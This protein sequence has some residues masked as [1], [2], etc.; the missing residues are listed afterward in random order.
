LHAVVQKNG[1]YTSFVAVEAETVHCICITAILSAI[2]FRR[3]V[4]IV[5]P[6]TPEIAIQEHRYAG[7]TPDIRSSP[8]PF[9]RFSIKRAVPRHIYIAIYPVAAVETYCTPSS[10]IPG[11]NLSSA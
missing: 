8:E 2:V 9:G 10:G 1:I 7:C 5:R 3:S 11:R 6:S 4:V